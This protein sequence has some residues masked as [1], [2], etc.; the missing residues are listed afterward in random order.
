VPT[1]DVVSGPGYDRVAGLSSTVRA[2]HEIRRVVSNL[3]VFDFANDERRMQVVSVHPGVTLDQVAEA[4]GFELVV[5]D[6]V[7]ETRLPTD[8][9]LRLIREVIDP[10]GLRRAEFGG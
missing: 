9:E 6:S 10:R 4:T 1:V 5:G 3:G 7:G 8:A 2:N